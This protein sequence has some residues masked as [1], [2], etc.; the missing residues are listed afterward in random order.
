LAYL[1]AGRTTEAIALLERVRDARV[2]KL[3]P[4]HPATLTTLNNLA[5]AYQDAGRTTEAIALLERVRDA[6]VKKRGPDHPDTL[7]TLNNLARAYWGAKQLDKSIPLFEQTLAIQR[8][9][10]GELHPVT[11]TTL[12]NLGTNYA[13]AGRMAEAIP[14][15]EQAHRDGREHASLGWVGDSLLTVYIRAGKSA[16]GSALVRENVEAARKALPADSPPLAGALARNGLALLQL[17]AWPDAESVLRECLAIREKEEADAWTAFNTK[18]MLGG[19]LLGLKKYAEAEP[20][21]LAGY[22]GMKEREAQ[23][24]P[25]GKIRVTESLERVV[26][27]YDA[28]DKKDKADGWRKKL[29]EAKLAGKPPAEA[30]PK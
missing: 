26:Q 22:E 1:A 5:M 27:L 29:E 8:K 12:A 28:W 21:L 15:L 24:P 11:L 17:K 2:K 16:E 3:G 19:A 4:D 13:Y 9:K 10:L 20:L 30:K 14:L 23:I 7:T 6:E 25:Q 18:S